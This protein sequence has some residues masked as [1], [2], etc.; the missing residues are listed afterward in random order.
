[1]FLAR[2]LVVQSVVHTED[3]KGVS[4]VS[5]V[6]SREDLKLST[7]PGKCLPCVQFLQTKLKSKFSPRNKLSLEAWP[8]VQLRIEVFPICKTLVSFGGYRNCFLMT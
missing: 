4:I 7:C 5:E 6:S 1:M 3:Q 2:L 8:G